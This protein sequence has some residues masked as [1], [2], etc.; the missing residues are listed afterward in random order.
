[1]NTEDRLLKTGEIIRMGDEQKFLYKWVPCNQ[2]V[3]SPVQ[4]QAEGMYRRNIKSES[5]TFR[6][7]DDGEVILDG[8][9]F[10]KGHIWQ[11]CSVSIGN[12]HVEEAYPVRRRVGH[13]GKLTEPSKPR[14]LNELA[15]F[16]HKANKKWWEDPITQ[17]PIERNKGELLMLIITELAEAVEGIR[18]NLWDDKLP[19][20]KMEE[21]EMAD[22]YIRILDFAGG[23]KINLEE[24][25]RNLMF[26]NKS[27]Y[28]LSICSEICTAGR[29]FGTGFY[30]SF[31]I[32]L[33][34]S[35]CKKFN[36]DLEGAFE[37]KMEYN[38]SREDH[39][40]EARL[41]EGGKKF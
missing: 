30:L 29:V 9:E 2:M 22:C 8:D 3:G 5:F 32:G 7:L 37:D 25:D 17:Q 26:E 40:H 31:A 33:I 4:S 18:K 14:T 36:L 39:S 6:L 23:F 21:V 35:Y 24:E 15:A 12:K 38:L 27:E 34:K 1:M 10:Y 19:H 11:F 41:K 13:C 28:I 20:R 16:V